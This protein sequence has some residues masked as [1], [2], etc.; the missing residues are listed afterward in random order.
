MLLFLADEDFNNH[1]VRGLRRRLPSIDLVRVQ[2]VGLDGSQDPQVL[3]WA[4]TAGRLLLT[5]D[6]ETMI[7]FAKE[8]VST[9]MSMPGVVEISQDLSIGEAIAEIQ[10]LAECSL[11][12]EWK[13]QIIFLPL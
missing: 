10:L 8:R 11:D 5:H 7:A 12:G 1:I 4:A 13:G 3:E 2:D 6:A 9:G